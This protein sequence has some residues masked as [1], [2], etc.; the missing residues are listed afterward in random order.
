M[1]KRLA[2][3]AA[4][5]L[6]VALLLTGCSGTAT[7][8]PSAST[9]PSA[10]AESSAAAEP[11]AST[12]PSSSGGA[13]EI[14]AAPATGAL[15]EGSAYTYNVPD[16]W[17]TPDQEIPGYT[18]DSW[19]ADL[20]ATGAFSD[21]VNVIASPAGE[22]VPDQIETAGT[23]ELEAVG[24]TDIEVGE[25]VTFAGSE[26]AHLSATMTQQGITYVIDQF[27]ATNDGQSFV[28]TFS[29]AEDTPEADRVEVYEAVLASWQWK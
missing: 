9:A 23:A 25:R 16:G 2:A 29:A 1:A 24:A 18:P 17:G 7:S 3:A 15:I 26:S 6:S 13:S 10:P 19:A 12:E 5:S 11:S 4:A 8:S 27:Y 21:N 22:I 14:D 28:V 20:T